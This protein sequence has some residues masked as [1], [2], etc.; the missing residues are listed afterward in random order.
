MSRYFLQECDF[1][2]VGK[3]TALSVAIFPSTGWA[4]R[5]GLTHWFAF[6]WRGGRFLATVESFAHPLYKRKIV[7]AKVQDTEYTDL[8]GRLR[9]NAPQR[10][11]R[12]TSHEL[13]KGE[14]A[15]DSSEK[16]Q[17]VIGHT[18][19]YGQV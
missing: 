19:I 15:P 18:T 8:Y 13:W 7:E 12:T 11:L 10:V 2:Q 9:W 1:S 14:L 5:N 6:V 16:G 3:I 4:S 17:P